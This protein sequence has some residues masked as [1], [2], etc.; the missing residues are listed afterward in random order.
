MDELPGYT[1][2]KGS[3]CIYPLFHLECRVMFH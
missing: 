3:M 2:V 1:H